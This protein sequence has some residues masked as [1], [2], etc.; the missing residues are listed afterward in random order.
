MQ[1]SNKMIMFAVIAALIVAA[2]ISFINLVPSHEVFSIVDGTTSYVYPANL[3]N[4]QYSI[5]HQN[6]S[7]STGSYAYQGNR[8]DLSYFNSSIYSFGSYMMY[9][10]S[11]NYTIF[12]DYNFRGNFYS[13]LHPTKVIVSASASYQNHTLDDNVVIYSPW[14]YN[15]LQDPYEKNVSN[16][17]ST[18]CIDSRGSGTITYPLENNSGTKLGQRYY[19]C[20]ANESDKLFPRNFEIYYNPPFQYNLTINLAIEAFTP[21]AELV[22]NFTIYLIDDGMMG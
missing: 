11:C 22:D 8:S 1:K 21:S 20:L 5:N 13:N 17:T 7:L 2:P 4:V 9:E 10:G 3:S 18:K 14:V 15:F 6:L 19:F 16:S 12:L